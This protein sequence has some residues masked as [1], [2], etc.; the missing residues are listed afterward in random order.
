MPDHSPTK[1]KP[2]GASPRC[3]SADPHVKITVPNKAQIPCMELLSPRRTWREKYCGYAS[4]GI[5]IKLLYLFAG[6]RSARIRTSTGAGIRWHPAV[7]RRTIL[8]EPRIITVWARRILCIR[9]A[10]NLTGLDGVVVD[11]LDHGLVSVVGLRESREL[12]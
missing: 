2:L 4:T 11:F 9:L 5:S 8:E 7:V 3:A 12:A 10:E 6:R 1:L